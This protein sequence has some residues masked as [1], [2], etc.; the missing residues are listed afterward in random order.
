M[1][2]FTFTTVVGV[3]ATL[4]QSGPGRSRTGNFDAALRARQAGHSSAS[5]LQ[6]DLGYEI[7]E[8]Y[9]NASSGLNV[10]QG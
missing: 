7:Y 10:W 6:V 5:P 3:L 8:G 1:L 9:T 2:S 4:V